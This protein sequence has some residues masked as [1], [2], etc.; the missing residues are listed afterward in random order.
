MDQDYAKRFTRKP[1]KKRANFKK[2]MLIA[3]F[4]FVLVGIIG[5]AWKMHLWN[6][7]HVSAF[8]SRHQEPQKET[9]PDVR[10][11]F[12]DELPTMHMSVSNP[13][14]ETPSPPLQ[15]PSPGYFLQFGIFNEAA[16]AGQL[17]LSLLLSGIETKVVKD[18]QNYRLLQGP[19]E[20]IVEAKGFQQ[21]W[22]KKGIETVIK[23]AE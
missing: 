17:R 4:L 3:V 11:S 21:K 5:V 10:F 13:V 19:Y 22:Q 9:A 16:Q 20:T 8:L 18:E 12:Y 15:P 1:P 2:V 23:K 14:K 7:P 6:K